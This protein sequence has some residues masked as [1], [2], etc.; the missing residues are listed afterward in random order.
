MGCYRSWQLVVGS[1]QSGVIFYSISILLSAFY[2]L[3][4]DVLLQC[5]A[6]LDS[7]SVLLID[8]DESETCELD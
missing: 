2:F 1:S 5:L 7:E 6:L 4:A 3:Y 8:D